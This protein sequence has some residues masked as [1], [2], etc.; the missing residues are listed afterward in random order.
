MILYVSVNI[1]VQSDCDIICMF[2]D[3]KGLLGVYMNMN[4]TGAALR[5][6]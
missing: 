4:I 6:N 2:Y 3:G 5:H 1:K